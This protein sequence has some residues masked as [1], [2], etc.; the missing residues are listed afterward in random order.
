MKF[1]RWL[2]GGL[3]LLQKVRVKMN[4]N[5]VLN[6]KSISANELSD[7]NPDDLKTVTI[8]K[9]VSGKGEIRLEGKKP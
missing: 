8:K 9:V 4:V 5:Y 2:L 3:K 1:L 7:V 6:G